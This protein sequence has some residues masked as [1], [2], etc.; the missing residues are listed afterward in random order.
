M[1][2]IVWKE[3]DLVSLKLKDD[4]YT[5]AQLTKS[6]MLRLYN[7]KNTEDKWEDTDLNE[8]E[9]LFTVFIGNIVFN[10]LATGKIKNKTAKPDLKK[11]EK[12]SYWLRGIDNEG[13]YLRGELFEKNADLVFAKPGNDT[14]DAPIVKGNINAK[15]NLDTVIEYELV[16]M[17][18]A[19]DLRE[20][21]VT[22]FETGI[23]FN[24][25]K[26]EVFPGLTMEAVKEYQLKKK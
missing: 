9:P 12:E 13:S 6:P 3:N 4:L 7:I 19:D 22:F 23:N 26:L 10:K 18:G 20:R 15:D 8:Y 21:L 16:N 25:Y 24:T 11:Y 14:W 1:A 5:I 2:R 17:Y